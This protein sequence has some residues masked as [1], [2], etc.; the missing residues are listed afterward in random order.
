MI[1]AML[2]K[3]KSTSQISTPLFAPKAIGVKLAAQRSIPAW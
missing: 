3:A 1:A 2:V